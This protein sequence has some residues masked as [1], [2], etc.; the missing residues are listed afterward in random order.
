MDKPKLLNVDKYTAAELRLSANPT[1]V[2]AVE[3]LEDGEP[4]WVNPEHVGFKPGE[5]P[6]TEDKTDDDRT[7]EPSG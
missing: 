7:R 5:A 4:C 1:I 6:E 2:K 3:H